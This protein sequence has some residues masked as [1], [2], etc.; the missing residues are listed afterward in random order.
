MRHKFFLFTALLVCL[1]LALVPTM[2]AERTTDRTVDRTDRGSRAETSESPGDETVLRVPYT[3]AK[4]AA[5]GQIVQEIGEEG[6]NGLRS[7]SRGDRLSK[8]P[9]L[10]VTRAQ[11]LAAQGQTDRAMSMF[12]QALG[13]NLSSS[14]E[15]DKIRYIANRSLADLYSGADHKEVYHLGAALQYAS[16]TERFEIEDRIQKLG[17]NVFDMTFDN[18]ATTAKTAMR[19]NDCATA[20]PATANIGFI[21]ISPGITV[22]GTYEWFVF[23]TTEEQVF[24]IETTPNVNSASDDT[25]L[26]LYTDCP[27]ASGTCNAGGGPPEC[28]AFDDDGGTVGFSSLIATDCLPAGTYYV[29]VGG[30]LDI[31][32]PGSF[33]INIAT[34]IC[35]QDLPLDKYEPDDDRSGSTG[36]GHPNPDPSGN[37][38]GRVNHQTQQHT[39]ALGGD[40]D[41]VN[42]KL[43]NDSHVRI[44]A[45]LE[46]GSFFND[47]TEVPFDILGE[48][49]NS[50]GE[51]CD[52]N[53]RLH[54]GQNHEWGGLCFDEI[55]FQGVACGCTTAPFPDGQSCLSSASAVVRNAEP[56]CSDPNDP[57]FPFINCPYSGTPEG[58]SC[59]DPRTFNYRSNQCANMQTNVSGD[60]FGCGV[61]GNP[62]CPP[63][64]IALQ[65]DRS[66]TDLGSEMAF[67]LPATTGNTNDPSVNGDWHVQVRG[68]ALQQ[69]EY[70]VR[71]VPEALCTNFEVEPNNGFLTPNPITL[72]DTINAMYNYSTSTTTRTNSRGTFVVPA[73]DSD[74]F[75]FNPP[76]PGGVMTFATDSHNS[77]FTDTFLELYVGPDPGGNFLFLNQTDD[78]GGE[79]L[80]SL[81]TTPFLPP[82]PV[83]FG[84]LAPDAEY[85][86]HVTAAFFQQDYPYVLHTSVAAGATPESEPNDVSDGGS[87]ME[88]VPG[89]KVNAFISPC[90]YDTYKVQL[91]E[92]T[93]MDF[94][95]EGP[96][97]TMMEIVDCSTAEREYALACSDDFGGHS[98]NAGISGCLAAGTYCIRVKGVSAWS[99]GPYD[100]EAAAL[101]TGCPAIDPPLISAGMDFGCRTGEFGVC[102]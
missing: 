81:L 14:P 98:L 89:G 60:P 68:F 80:L 11:V 44:S 75:S 47:F 91:A 65:D 67:C 46:H 9:R 21:T 79:N 17:G 101:S 33:D 76:A 30:W 31:V 99:E 10:L 74:L 62:P 42:F 5:M 61:S 59:P 22:P 93:L 100:F 50:G 64:P 82:A 3:P 40:H 43:H 27:A 25:D 38:W 72:G 96:M 23:T 35:P 55:G 54:Y 7:V 49:C 6:S 36:I 32:A 12:Q 13:S 69:M 29:E 87:P 66:A 24:S 53:I 2:A 19:T 90:D 8:D 20:T 41:F 18:G 63:E 37:G 39:I 71:V 78:D 28:I 92:A 70:Q 94:H 86:L 26:S 85:L 48:N 52:P 34:S 16:P 58:D 56:R 102:P 73:N 97:D 1:G 77:N 45:M 83:L 15:N 84:G 95:T 4:A 57:A 51:A 88:I